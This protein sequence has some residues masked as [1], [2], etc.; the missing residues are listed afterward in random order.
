LN[1][2]A[3]IEIRNENFDGAVALLEMAVQADP[4]FPLPYL[5]LGIARENAGDKA[6]ALE[7]YQKYVELEGDRAEEVSVW[8]AEMQ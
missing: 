1:N 8:I 3:A 7:A 4:G 2:L 5:N 6:A